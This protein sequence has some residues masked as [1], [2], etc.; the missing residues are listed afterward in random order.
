MTSKFGATLLYLRPTL[1]F[2]SVQ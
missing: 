2:W 1:H